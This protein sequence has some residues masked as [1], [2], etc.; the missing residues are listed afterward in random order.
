MLNQKNFFIFFILVVI[1]GGL[2][3]LSNRDDSGST[4][5]SEGLNIDSWQSE[6]GAKVLY[7]FAPEL[8]MV[9]VRIVFD[10][11]SARD[12][13]KPGLASMMNL[14]LDHGAGKWNTNQIEERFDS[15]G[16]QFATSALRDMAVVSLRSLTDEAWLEK[17]LDTTAAILQKPKFV[18]E[19]L[20]RERKRVLVGLKN[21]KESAGALASIA[22]YKALYGDHPYATPTSGDEDSVKKISL[23]DITAFYKKY[24]V[25]KNATVVI[26][27]AVDKSQ[28]K[29]IVAQLVDGLASG[30]KAPALPDV[31]S[32]NKAETIKQDHP[33]KQTNIMVGQ[34]GKIR[35]DE[36]YFAL[37]VGNH[38]LGGSGFG[39]RIVEEIR[40][41]RGLAY[42]SYSYFSPMRKK[43]PF[44]MGL[45]TKNEQAEEA[46]KVL[47][48]TVN[49]FIEDGPT[50]E[51]LISSKKNITGGFPLRIDS[52]RDITEYV[53]MIGFYDLPLDYLTSFNDNVEEVSVDQIKDAFERRVH[54]DKMVIVMVGGEAKTGQTEESKNNSDSDKK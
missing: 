30:E 15:V 16:A 29:T 8:P 45:Q 52:N 39:S 51:E 5:R 33:S 53:A 7:V 17:A 2:Y 32:I 48:E 41:N 49:K 46:L 37:Y 11:G 6:K 22:F 40:E 13:G 23:D 26:V 20:E 38:I 54:P 9:D 12:N 18:A 50:E 35:G 28:A 1:V 34:E 24:Y 42:S 3:A 31:Q 36:D 21:Q 25:A 43:G 19:E 4:T 27:G 47:F 10:A 14:L 44:V